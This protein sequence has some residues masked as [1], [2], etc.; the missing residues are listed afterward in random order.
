ME[1]IRLGKELIEEMKRTH[2]DKKKVVLSDKNNVKTTGAKKNNDHKDVNDGQELRDRI[3]EEEEH[4][5]AISEL[6]KYI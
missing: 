3:N 5:S 6:N 4:G 2:K 1:K